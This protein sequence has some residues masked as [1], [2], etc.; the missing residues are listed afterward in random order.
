MERIKKIWENYKKLG[1][2]KSSTTASAYIKCVLC[3]S[4]P[5]RSQLIRGHPYLFRVIIASECKVAFRAVYKFLLTTTDFV[6]E[7]FQVGTG[8]LKQKSN[9]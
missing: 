1:P 2:N 3:L 9:A 8:I 4:N 7:L 5:S 6:I